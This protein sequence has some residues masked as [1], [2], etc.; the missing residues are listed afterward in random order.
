ME[1]GLSLG[2][3]GRNE[4]VLEVGAFVVA[5][6]VAYQM[7]DLREALTINRKN[8]MMVFPFTALVSLTL[9]F[10]NGTG[11]NLLDYGFASGSISLISVSHIVLAL[12]LALS[13]VQGA[14]GLLGHNRML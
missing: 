11:I 10:A 7:H 3:T 1:F 6:F 4:M 8:V 9:L 13:T 5:A 12:F 2:S 14:R